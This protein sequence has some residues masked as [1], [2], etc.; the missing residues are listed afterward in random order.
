VSEDAGIDPYTGATLALAVI[1]STR[2]T[3]L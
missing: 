3:R 1:P 2:T